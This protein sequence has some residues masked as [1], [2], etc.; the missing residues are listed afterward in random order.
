M[1]T[2]LCHAFEGSPR[3]LPTCRFKDLT[4]HHSP[5]CA[6][7]MY[8]SLPAPCVAEYCMCP[9]PAC[10]QFFFFAPWRD[11]GRKDGAQWV[12]REIPRMWSLAVTRTW[13][14]ECGGGEYDS[15]RYMHNYNNLTNYLNGEK[16]RKRVKRVR[17]RTY[18]AKP[19]V[20]PQE[21][22]DWKEK[23]IDNQF[24]GRAKALVTC[25]ITGLSCLK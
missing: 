20:L 11:S 13:M 21:I 19:W 3:G 18:E 9:E 10:M 1:Y 15:A 25:I 24:E 2:L 12:S 22:I 4:I 7:C 17:V 6:R 23:C 5:I 8:A 14:L 16:L